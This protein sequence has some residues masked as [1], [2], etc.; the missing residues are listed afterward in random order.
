MIHNTGSCEKYESQICL[1]VI[2][3]G[4]YILLTVGWEDSGKDW[5]HLSSKIIHGKST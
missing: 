4:R 5:L 1:Q 2:A 3:W